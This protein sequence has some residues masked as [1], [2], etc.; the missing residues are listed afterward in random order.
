MDV[1]GKDLRIQGKLIRIARLE[2][3]RYEYLDDPVAAVEQL[4]ASGGQRIDIF[5]FLQKLSE[6]T[7]KYAYRMEWDNLAAISV[8]TY[9]H[10]WNKQINGKTRNMVRKAEKKGVVVREIPFD[11]A[12]VTGIWRIYNETP[13]R[14]GKPFAH[15]GKD[16][17][18]IRRMKATFLDRSIFIGTFVD[19]TLVGFAKLVTDEHREQAALMHIVSMVEHRDKSPTNALIAQAVRSCADRQ[20]PF[21][22]YSH[23][24]YG[25][26]ERDSLSDFKEYNGFQRVD[27]PRYYVP[28]TATGRAALALGLH[29][30]LVEHVPE[31]LLVKLRQMRTNW[32]N[33]RLPI[34]Q[35]AQS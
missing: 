20:I 35:E 6:P 10:W 17:D 5:T 30:P 1:C 8:S 23:F 29:H 3:D 11:D 7:P 4:R 34:V 22:V 13:M 14:Q 33:R 9:D 28:L 12:L 21:L 26:K 32:Y 2:G 27:L 24:A 25:N 31:S 15:F 19:E 16:V 18:T